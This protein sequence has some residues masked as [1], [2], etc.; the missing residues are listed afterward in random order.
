MQRLWAYLTLPAEIS[1]F[2]A[3]YLQRMNRLAII[4]FCLHLPAFA[5][6]AA[7]AGTSVVQA[8]VLTA[9]VLVGP[10]IAYLT[11]QNP[12]RL[13]VVYGFTAM[14]MGG[15]L[16]HFGQG[17]MQ[18][19]M[20]FYF[21]VLLALLVVF[22][23]PAV[24]LVAAA[25]VAVHHLLLWLLLPASAFN[26]DASV[27]S[28]VVHAVFV[29]LE[30]VAAVFVA[31][32]FFTNVIGLEKIVGDRTSALD[33]RNRDLRLVLDNVGQ[34]FLTVRADATMSEERSAILA[35]WL[36][37]APASNSFIDYVAVA[38]ADLAAW[39]S[40]CWEAAF[41]DYLPVD[42]AIAQLPTGFRHQGRH[43]SLRY[44]PIEDANGRLDS[45]LV[46]VSDVTAEV[47]RQ[48]TEF[49]H[50]ELL[51]VL[52]W[53]GKDRS[54][55]LDFLDETGG[56]IRRLVG[57][58]EAAPGEAMRWLHTIK[59]NTATFGVESVSALCHQLED[60]L[61]DETRPLR[62]DEHAALAALWDGFVARLDALLGKQ[63]ARSV[64]VAD[65]ELEA[66]VVALAAGRPV[67]EISRTILGWR[68]E[69]VANQFT[70]LAEQAHRIGRG[71]GKDLDV[72]IETHG[73]RL[74]PERWAS[75]W[76][77]FVHAVR[78]AIDHGIEPPEERIQH[79]KSPRGQ[80]GLVAM[81]DGGEVVIGI[82]DD[83]RGIDWAALAVRA[84]NRGLAS[85]SRADLIDA[86]FTDGISTRSAV[87]ELSGRGVGLGCLRSACLADGGRVV[88]SSEP[89]AG[90]TMQFRFPSTVAT[91]ESGSTMRP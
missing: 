64:Q 86:L 15:L 13:S 30:S 75:F 44:Q 6:V 74:A 29:V 67:D 55:Y 60:R 42:V 39:M 71:V 91:R 50:R 65:H 38:D 48:R 80:I 72:G 56:L 70:R 36:G 22:A 62:T 11:F 16:V 7:L 9:F 52:D 43:L 2:E 63:T 79:G 83:G 68:L 34:G 88:V 19:E 69:P 28:V 17:P 3:R 85:E 25:T 78:N 46:V 31:R 89:G 58:N 18:I 10:V 57:A 53:F 77:S 73:L 51:A 37:P 26:Y 8:V 12:R 76:S 14:L 27:W 47:E 35:E 41:D 54:G 4:V 21:F 20:H 61:V 40:V 49:E 82:S 45:L 66:V 81:L 90:T 84:Q 87:T 59:G 24:I 1:E 23:N 33:T 32:S 5:V